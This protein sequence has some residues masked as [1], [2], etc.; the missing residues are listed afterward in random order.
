MDIPFDDILAV[1]R[2]TG[3][4]KRRSVPYEK[5]GD[6]HAVRSMGQDPNA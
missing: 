3:D 4:L 2:Q 6:P 5:L 1:V